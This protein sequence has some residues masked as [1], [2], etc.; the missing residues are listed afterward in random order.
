MAINVKLKAGTIRKLE[1][2][3]RSGSRAFAGTL[4][5]VIL[6]ETNKWAQGLIK[7]I[8][9]DSRFSELKSS[10]DLRGQLGMARRQ[11]K[12]GSDTDADD[13]IRLLHTYQIKS[14]KGLR[15]KSINVKFPSLNIL[16]DRLVRSLSSINSKGIVLPGPPQSWF[17]WWEFG[18]Q[19]EITSLTVLRRTIGKLAQ[20]Q[21]R[22]QTKGRSK[23]LQAMQERSRS[24]AALQVKSRPAGAD[25]HIFARGLISEKYK[26]FGKIFPATIGKKVQQYIR[27]NKTRIKKLFTQVRTA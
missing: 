22:G 25:S 17:R 4:Q 6:N 1:T 27:N 12:R 10:E 5:T 23:L 18:D 14:K 13:L 16:E 11:F 7:A 20:T 19:G 21:G 2:A 24:G 15:T 9:K 26:N 3:I 8:E